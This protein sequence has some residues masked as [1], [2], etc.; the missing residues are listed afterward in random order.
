[1]ILGF[2]FDEGVARNGGRE[3]AKTGPERF[4]YWLKRY[5][6]VRNPQWKVD[7]SGISVSDAG[8]IPPCQTLEEGHAALTRATENILA[9]GGIPFVV[10]GGNDQSYPNARALLNHLGGR[11]GGVINVDAH[12]DVRPLI[13]GRA[14]SGSSFRQLLEDP[15]FDGG[16]FIEFA[17][18]GAQCSAE[19]AEYIQNRKARILWLDEVQRHEG[20]VDSFRNALGKLTWQCQSLF[21]SFDLDSVAACDAPGVSCPGVQG[22]KAHDALMIAYFS[23]LHLLVSLFDLS[24]YNPAIEDERTGRL[25]A[26][27]FYHFCLGFA[28]REKKS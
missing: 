5:G 23:G 2:P 6:T 17:T 7:L 19:H 14:H 26:A 12:L 16:N 25:A 21:V 4:R 1:V 8:D 11:P 18:Q 22:L 15:A 28:M 27:V 24:E 20:A 9:A 3:G 10:G 13:A